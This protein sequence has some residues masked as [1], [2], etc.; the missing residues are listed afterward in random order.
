M[1]SDRITLTV[2][3]RDEYA[4]AVR[5]TAVALASR[6][7]VPIDLLDDVRIAVE[8]AYI[9]ACEHVEGDAEIT[10]VFTLDPTTMR[11]VVGPVGSPEEAGETDA[12]DKYSRF[13]LE[14]VLDEFL[15]KETEQG[16]FLHLTKSLDGQA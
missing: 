15:L 3:P 4:R 10:F 7:D 11:L 6:M 2:P 13:I 12:T 9:Y 8:E 5:M 14:S 16:R 1:S